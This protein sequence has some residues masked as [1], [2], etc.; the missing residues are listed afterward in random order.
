MS[1]LARLG[2]RLRRDHS[3]AAAVEF[4]FAGPL[5]ILMMMAVLQIGLAMQSYN[6]IRNVAAETARFAVVQY[7]RGST[8]NVDALEAQAVTI[9][10]S[11][12][13]VLKRNA[14]EAS[15]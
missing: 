2:S 9:A 14:F 6:A 4:A 11:G 10:T 15:I 12:A 3:G 8:P 5:V 13:Y 7:Q 1:E